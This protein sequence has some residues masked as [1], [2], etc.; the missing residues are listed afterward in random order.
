MPLRENQKVWEDRRTVK[1]VEDLPTAPGLGCVRLVES[2]E[3]VYVYLGSLAGWEPV[4]NYNPEPSSKFPRNYRKEAILAQ[5][6]RE[7]R[8]K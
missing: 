2:T 6:A 4:A 3:E 7:A 8:V 5:K 1:K